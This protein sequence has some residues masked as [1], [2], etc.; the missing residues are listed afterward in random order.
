MTAAKYLRSFRSELRRSLGA[1]L[2]TG[3][4]HRALRVAIFAPL[5]GW[6]LSWF[7]ERTGRTVLIDQ[8]IAVFLTEPIGV[9]GALL[10]LSLVLAL[11]ALEQTSLMTIFHGAATRKPVGAMIALRIALNNVKD[12]LALARRIVLRI[13]LIVVPFVGAL[14]LVYQTLLTKYDI[15]YYL[16]ERP[17]EYKLALVLGALIG[18]GL[19]VSLLWLMSRVILA[20]PI[21]LFERRTPGDAFADSAR[22]S[23]GMRVRMFTILLAWGVGSLALGFLLGLPSWLIAKVLIP[24]FADNVHVLIFLLGALLLA[25]L[26]S[27]LVTSLLSSA[28]LS[29]AVIEM[30]GPVDT[31]DAQRFD[32]EQ[33]GKPISLSAWQLA[34][35]TAAVALGA[36]VTGLMML[37]N[38]D[39]P[40][41]A[42]VV[43]HR[44]SSGKAPENT[45]AAIEQAIRDGAGWAEID[46]QRSADGIVVVMHDR[47]LRRLG[48]SGLIVGESPLDELAKVDIG[49]W[50]DPKFADQ[51]LPTLEEVLLLCQDRIDVNIEL[52]YYGWD[53][54]LV[55]AVIDIVERTGMTEQI[56]L[57]SLDNRA[58]SQAKK[59]RPVWQVGQLTA[60]LLGDLTRVEADFLA[61]HS[62]NA[63]ASFIDHAHR[64][65]K[66]VHVWTVNDVPGLHAMYSLGVDSIITDFPARA[67]AL[68]KQRAELEP[69]QRLLLRAGLLLLDEP[70]HVDPTL[71]VLDMSA[72]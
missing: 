67:V 50:F 30:Y 12:V 13:V 38:T 14:A 49:S 52:K 65:G 20:L 26:V 56:V 66:Q 45:L 44:G 31:N 32:K 37:G 39:L 57:M 48:G 70:I 61:V 71:D 19:L 18:A 53:E 27:G 35:V 36:L 3:V 15:N 59:L 72:R 63:T 64:N 24:V 51:R 8:D 22:R 55:P 21:L 10:L 9:I 28:A 54:Q 33:A 58:V 1:L 5:L 43:A 69:A 68:R 62:R 17:G 7:L 42:A 6:L 16:S 29:L 34:A 60:V 23:R 2:I 47:D 4:L 46:V 25:L 11:A 40:D 41:R